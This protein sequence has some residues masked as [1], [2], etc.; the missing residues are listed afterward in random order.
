[1]KQVS[2][3]LLGPCLSFTAAQNTPSGFTGS[4]LNMWLVFSA[5]MHRHGRAWHASWPLQRPSPT[6][7]PLI[8]TLPPHL[9]SQYFLPPATS[10]ILPPLSSSGQFTHQQPLI[11]SSA[12]HTAFPLNQRVSCSSTTNTSIS[13]RQW[14]NELHCS[15][16]ELLSS[17]RC[18]RVYQWL[19]LDTKKSQRAGSYLATIAGSSLGIEGILKIFQF[20]DDVDGFR[21]KCIHFFVS[22]LHFQ[23]SNS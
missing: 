21:A 16:E 23:E 20:Q 12:S 9:W 17:A 13:C 6:T 3:C 14:A 5:L 11:Q 2:D 22:L 1:M 4:I 8:S 19:I 7:L 18:T 10:L 15:V